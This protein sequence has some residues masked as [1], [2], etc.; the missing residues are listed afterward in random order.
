MSERVKIRKVG[1]KK[2]SYHRETISRNFRNI[3]KLP[4]KTLNS[5][6]RIMNL[7]LSRHITH[8]TLDN[9]EKV[10]LRFTRQSIV[11]ISLPRTPSLKKS[12]VL[13]QISVNV[14]TPGF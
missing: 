14:W 1:I 8:L 9:H 11:H 5:T 2:Q 10:R 4:L 12:G 7:A 6:N 3:K 13:N